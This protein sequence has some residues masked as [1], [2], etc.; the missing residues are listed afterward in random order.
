M[1]STEAIVRSYNI[2]IDDLDRIATQRKKMNSL[3]RSDRN[4]EAMSTAY[5]P[6]SNSSAAAYAAIYTDKYVPQ[7]C[8]RKRSV[9][10]NWSD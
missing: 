1:A 6:Y 3:E 7:V 10:L 5:R 2:A 8:V 9:M 4:G